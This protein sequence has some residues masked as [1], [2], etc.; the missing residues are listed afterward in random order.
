MPPLFCFSFFFVLLHRFS[1]P[2][3]LTYCEVPTYRLLS[4]LRLR[5]NAVYVSKD[6][7][8]FLPPP[9]TP[10]S[11]LITYGWAFCFFCLAVTPYF[12]PLR[13]PCLHGDTIPERVPC[14]PPGGAL[15]CTYSGELSFLFLVPLFV[16]KAGPRVIP[17]HALVHPF[18]PFFFFLPV[19]SS[20]SLGRLNLCRLVRPLA[21]SAPLPNPVSLDRT[22][23]KRFTT[24]NSTIP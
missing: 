16:D 24:I 6:K 7:K 19:L 1:L 10:H 17:V 23:R 3:R 14:P 21:V 20:S 9:S 8:T 13:C 5:V 22:L 2:P 11:C 4:Q 18:E 15:F 12:F